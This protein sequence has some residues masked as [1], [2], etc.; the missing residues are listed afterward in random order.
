MKKEIMRVNKEVAERKKEKIRKKQE[1]AREKDDK[2]NGSSK[3]VKPDTLTTSKRGRKKL[4]KVE[5]D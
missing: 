5:K 3:R 4:I 1:A 2:K